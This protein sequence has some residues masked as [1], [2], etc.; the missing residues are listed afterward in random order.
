[1]P[2]VSSYGLADIVWNLSLK[3]NDNDDKQ[4]SVAQNPCFYS[5][6]TTLENGMYQ[7]SAIIELTEPFPDTI[8]VI[9]NNECWVY[10]NLRGGAADL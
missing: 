2:V 6:L 1:M 4:L 3:Y 10:F 5:S 7:G 8:Y 9:T